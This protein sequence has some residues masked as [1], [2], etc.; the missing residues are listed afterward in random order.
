MFWQRSKTQIVVFFAVVVV[1]AFAVRCYSRPAR[2]RRTGMTEPSAC[3]IKTI[4]IPLND[5][6]S[7][8]HPIQD[9]P[10]QF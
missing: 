3:F 9:T 8:D 4:V 10:K 6:N 1:R 2:S 5:R 7:K